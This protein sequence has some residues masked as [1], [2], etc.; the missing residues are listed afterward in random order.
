MADRLMQMALDPD[1]RNALADRV[2]GE[3]GQTTVSS[4]ERPL[5]KLGKNQLPQ[6]RYIIGKDLPEGTFDF[7]WVWGEGY[8]S[9]YKTD[10]NTTL[11]NN[12]YHENVG[13]AYEYQY[14]QCLHLQCAPGNMLIIGGNLVVEISRSAKL[15]IEL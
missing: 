1:K 4:G 12:L 5:I 15:D 13:V 14:R 2:E 9:L 10:E 7:T 8:L 11:G 6:G 3:S